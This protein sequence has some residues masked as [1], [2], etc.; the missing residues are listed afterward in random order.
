MKTTRMKEGQSTPAKPGIWEINK[1]RVPKERTSAPTKLNTISSTANVS[2]LSS[3]ALPM[4][5]AMVGIKVFV[6]K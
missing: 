3:L 6:F 1:T 4:S 5:L 2:L